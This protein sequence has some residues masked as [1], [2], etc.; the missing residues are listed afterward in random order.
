[1]K[2]LDLNAYGVSEM[3]SVEI[4]NLRGGGVIKDVY[5]VLKD[6]DKHWDSIKEHFMDGWNSYECDCHC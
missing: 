3:N 5:D 4:L 6:L 2:N 1:M